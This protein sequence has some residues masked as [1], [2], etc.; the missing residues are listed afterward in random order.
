M[1]GE[2]HAAVGRRCGLDQTRRA[3]WL[4]EERSGHCRMQRLERYFDE[5]SPRR[6][7]S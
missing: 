7:Q 3:D 4:H 1:L 2:L 6:L 5:R